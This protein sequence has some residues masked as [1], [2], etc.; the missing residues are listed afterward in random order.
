MPDLGQWGDFWLN[1]ARSLM[2]RTSDN[3][4]KSD[5]VG[6][7]T[8][9]YDFLGFL[10]AIGDLLT[11][12]R[13]CLGWGYCTTESPVCDHPWDGL[14]SPLLEDAVRLYLNGGDVGSALLG[15]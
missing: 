8:D 15:G 6:S 9:L 1:V 14:W 12:D 7:G 13:R 5:N 2:S 10:G 11:H 4:G 3:P